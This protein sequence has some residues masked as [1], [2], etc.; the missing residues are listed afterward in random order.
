MNFRVLAFHARMTMLD[1]LCEL[2][3]AKVLGYVEL[4]SMLHFFAEGSSG[5]IF[6][7]LDVAEYLSNKM[8]ELDS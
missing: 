4:Q 5:R 6:Y 3:N 1:V 7:S 8:S 2:I